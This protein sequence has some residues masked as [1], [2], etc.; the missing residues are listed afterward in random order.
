MRVVDKFTERTAGVCAVCASTEQEQGHFGCADHGRGFAQD[1]VTRFG[2]VARM[3]LQNRL[4]RVFGRDIF[5]QFE[6]YSTGAFFLRDA[7]RFTDQGRDR[8][9]VHDLFW[10]SCRSDRRAPTTSMIWNWPCFDF[11]IGFWP[12]DHD[13]RHAPQMR[14]S[15]WCGKVGG[16]RPECCHADPPPYR[17]NARTSPP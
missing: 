4:I 16:T 5:R 15:R 17:S 9:A 11:L 14:I 3:R 7:E 10:T 6:Q 8:V 12:G 1:G 13:Q 2:I